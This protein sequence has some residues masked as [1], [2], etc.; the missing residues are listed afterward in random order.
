MRFAVLLPLL[1]GLFPPAVERFG[2]RVCVPRDQDAGAPGPRS[3]ANDD[4]AG[5]HAAAPYPA[6]ADG[7]SSVGRRRTL[8]W[9]RDLRPLGSAMTAMHPAAC[10]V[11]TSEAQLHGDEHND[12]KVDVDR[13]GPGRP[14]GGV[15]P[16]THR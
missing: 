4:R 6:V 8:T 2:I 11:A 3:F 12:N 15:G 9:G 10:P 16:W 1:I 13:E 7:F 5:R 14:N